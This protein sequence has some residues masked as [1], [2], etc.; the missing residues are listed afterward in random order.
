MHQAT[1]L[2]QSFALWILVGIVVVLMVG[3][4]LLLAQPALFHAISVLLQGPAQQ[5]A[6]V[7]NGAPTPC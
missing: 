6:P 3:T 7:C 2:R 1:A 4:I 5:M